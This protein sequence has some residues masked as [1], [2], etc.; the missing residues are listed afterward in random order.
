MKKLLVI[1]MVICI[2]FSFVSCAV[3]PKNTEQS[4]ANLGNTTNENLASQSPPPA[5]NFSSVNDLVE[6]KSMLEKSEEEVKK[7]LKEKNYI[8]TLYTKKEIEMFFEEIGNLQILHLTEASG[9]NLVDIQYVEDYGTI[10]TVYLNDDGFI[11]LYRYLPDSRLLS[12]SDKTEPIS[13]P[14]AKEKLTVLNQTLDFQIMNDDERGYRVCSTLKAF[15]S[16]VLLYLTDNAKK[17]FD[18]NAIEQNIVETTLNEL[19]EEYQAK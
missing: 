19:I 4:D 7:F 6:L 17:G 18:L 10:D 16:Y 8:D 14:I 12:G 11:R 3:N 15:D 9:Y 13:R 1:F 2:I 5:L